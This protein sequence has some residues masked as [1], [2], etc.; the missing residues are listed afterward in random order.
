[1]WRPTRRSLIV[2]QCSDRGLFTQKNSKKF[3]KY[4]KKFEKNSKKIRK[5][6]EKNPK[7]FQKIQGFFWRFKIRIPYLGVKKS[8]NL[9]F[10]SFFIHKILVH[11]KKSE[12]KLKNP[13]NPKKILGFFLG[14]LKS[15]H[16]WEWT[17][18]RI[19]HCTTASPMAH[20][21]CSSQLLCIR[22]QWI[23]FHCDRDAHPLTRFPNFRTRLQST[24]RDFRVNGL[25][26][27]PVSTISSDCLVLGPN[28]FKL[29]TIP[30]F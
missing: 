4:S 11:P 5:K 16:I 29:T 22:S 14:D 27:M 8:S 17:I 30:S 18:P 19:W 21:G 2:G 20:Y 9:V 24:R 7:K 25:W 28:F 10:K 3:E 6:F 26:Q 15:L 1:M 12:K 13:N 23:N